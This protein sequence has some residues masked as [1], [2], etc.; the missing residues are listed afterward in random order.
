MSLREVKRE[1][2]TEGRHEIMRGVLMRRSC[3]LQAKAL[4]RLVPIM[5]PALH[6]NDV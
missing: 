1:M 3:T 6:V 5:A 2:N 4:L